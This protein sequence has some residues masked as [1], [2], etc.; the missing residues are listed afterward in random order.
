MRLGDLT[1]ANKVITRMVTSRL[2]EY[3]LTKR[4]VIEVLINEKCEED[5]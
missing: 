3:R 2:L 1:I 5:P 4:S